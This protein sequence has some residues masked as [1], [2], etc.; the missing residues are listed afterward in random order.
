VV[1]GG[2]VEGAGA[3]EGGAWE[4]RTA[5]RDNGR[6]GRNKKQQGTVRE[7]LAGK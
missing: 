7:R 2:A 3:V 6:R 1:A 5:L 4:Q